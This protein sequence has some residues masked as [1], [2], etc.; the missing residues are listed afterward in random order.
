MTL[1]ILCITGPT[2][3]DFDRIHC[4]SLD[5]AFERAANLV[6]GTPHHIEIQH[7]DMLHVIEPTRGIFR[8][9]SEMPA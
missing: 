3:G 9:A 7:G 2:T 1:L 4:A 6:P 5:D 8:P